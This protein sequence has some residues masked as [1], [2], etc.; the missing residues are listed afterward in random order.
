M[1][2][3]A[4]MQSGV[5]AIKPNP[6]PAGSNWARWL[7]Q[8]FFI[9]FNP[10]LHQQFTQFIKRRFD[11]M[12]FWLAL[13]VFN[14]TVFIGVG[15][16]KSTITFLPTLESGKQSLLFDPKAGGHFNVLHETGQGDG[17]MK[18]G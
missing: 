5:T 2:S 12:M 7:I 4:R 18:A 15:N 10:G 16:R 9:K 17:R 14:Q 11:A 13:D 6:T 8:I 3:G 1:Q